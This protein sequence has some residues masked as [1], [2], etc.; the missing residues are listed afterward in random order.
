VDAKAH[1]IG[2]LMNPI[3]PKRDEQGDQFAAAFWR[4]VLQN[5]GIA[6]KTDEPAWLDRPAMMRIPVSS[7]AVL[8]RLKAFC[9]PYDFVLAPVIREGDLQLDEEAEKPILVTRFNKDSEEW[10]AATYYNVRSGEPCS[11]TTGESGSDNVLPVRSYRSVV[12]AYVNNAES[13][14]NG[15]DGS[16]CHPWTR[17]ILQRTHVVARVSRRISQFASVHT[18]FALRPRARPL[19]PG[20][21]GSPVH[22]L[23]LQPNDSLTIP[24]MALLIDFI[25]FVSSTN[26][27]QA[28]EV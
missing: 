12:N 15:P 14:F 28:T 3:R 18:A 17:G 20:F 19:G 16:Q 10:S 9:K 11:I 27:I 7:P 1:G 22:S 2:Y 8:G 25:R 5:E 6:L 21:S 24:R 23:S 26:A 4:K 13:K